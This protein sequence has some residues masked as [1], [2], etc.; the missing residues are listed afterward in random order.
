V[1]V[2]DVSLAPA[3]SNPFCWSAMAVGRQGDRYGLWVAT[4]A[5]APGLVPP[6][7][8]ALEPTGRTVTLGLPSLGDTASVR[9]DGEWTRPLG[10]LGGLA[11]ANCEAAA[12]LRWARLPFW[13]E[14]PG[15]E[16]V[17]GDI[18]YDRSPELEFAETA[19][20]S[21]PATCPKRVPPWTPP[22]ADLIEP[23][24]SP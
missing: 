14:R 13:V 24:S 18:R 4:V 10:E 2:F 20:T 11:R 22:R 21:P 7:A 6:G 9:W 19:G 12:Y 17:L 5:L 15:H 3:P 16:L 8:C 23:R 1:E